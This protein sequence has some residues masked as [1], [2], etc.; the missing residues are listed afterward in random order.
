MVFFVKT[1]RLCQCLT[2]ELRMSS[3]L[4]TNIKYVLDSWVDANVVPTNTATQCWLNKRVLHMPG[5]APAHR[6]IL[7]GLILG[8]LL[9]YIYSLNW[10][11]GTLSLF[12][13]LHVTKISFTFIIQLLFKLKIET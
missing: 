8:L 13:N 7:I 4:L 5:K 3:L 1:P 10:L 11:L 6:E 12:S 9:S 2:N